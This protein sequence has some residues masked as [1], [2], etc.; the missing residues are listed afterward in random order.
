MKG[1][2]ELYGR[3]LYNRL[4]TIAKTAAKDC[5][6]G[7]DNV[8]FSSEGYRKLGRRYALRYLEVAK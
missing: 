7:D 5:L 3:D 4:L 8:H 6:P 2:L 1:I